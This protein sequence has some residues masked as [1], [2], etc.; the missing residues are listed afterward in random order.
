MINIII[1]RT[2]SIT[3]KNALSLWKSRSQNIR[4]APADIVRVKDLIYLID[5]DN[6]PGFFGYG[7]RGLE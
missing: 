4:Q 2:Q 6:F 7:S 3:K 5:A 1:D